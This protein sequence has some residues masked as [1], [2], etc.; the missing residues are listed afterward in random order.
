MDAEL[1]VSYT[2]EQNYPNPFNPSTKI[3]FSV[4][5]QGN[6][7]LTVHNILGQEV[8]VLHNGQ[9][10]AGVHT[11]TFDASRLGSGIYFYTLSGNNVNITKKMM[12]VK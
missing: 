8:E 2:L 7:K 4:P 3:K 9:L 11:A 10:N 1:P 6:F 12:L 5:E